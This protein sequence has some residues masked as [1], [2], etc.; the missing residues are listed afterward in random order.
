MTHDRVQPASRPEEGHHGKAAPR[1]RWYVDG[2]MRQVQDASAMRGR[3]P[4]PKL[5]KPVGRQ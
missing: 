5:T 4:T 2:S 3:N 1:R